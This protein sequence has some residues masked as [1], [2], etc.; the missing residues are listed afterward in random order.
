MENCNFFKKKSRTV[1]EAL[2]VDVDSC[3][4]FDIIWKQKLKMSQPG[5]WL[6]QNVTTQIKTYTFGT[7]IL[8]KVNEEFT[9]KGTKNVQKNVE[10]RLAATFLL[11]LLAES[12]IYNGLEKKQI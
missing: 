1:S 12:S 10:M 6:H 4:N 9:L 11:A 8:K 2:G 5:S 7:I 3:S